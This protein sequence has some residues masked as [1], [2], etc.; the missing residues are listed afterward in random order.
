MTVRRNKRKGSRGHQWFCDL[1][2]DGKRVQR[3]IKG[4]RTRAQALKAE[5]VIRTKLFEKKYGLVEQAECRFDKFVEATFLPSKK[6]K[7]SYQSIVSITKALTAFFGKR[8]LSDIDSDLIEKYKQTRIAEN[9]TRGTKRS[10]LRVNKELQ[11]LSSLFTL[12]MEKELTATRPKVKLFQV[13]GERERYLSPDEEKGLMAAL[14]ESPWL[15]NIVTMALHTGMRRGEIFS[16]QWF[17]VN[18]EREA[19][20][21]RQTKSGK[22]RLVPMNSTVRAML[23]SL[24]KSS[25]YVFPS[26]KTGGR[27]IDIKVGFMRAVVA[28]KLKDFRFHDLRHT[29]ATRMAA[30]GADAFTLC[31]IFGWSDI[32]MALRYTHAMSD[33]K[34][35]A[36]EN[37]AEKSRSGGKKVTKGK[38]Q[39]RQLAVKS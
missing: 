18:F 9:T 28:A 31:S 22:D 26:P 27:L 3:V 10:P 16:L 2:I 29:A 8:L 17:D 25:G 23:E 6:L 14:S 21:L 7:K 36:V 38:R 15:R 11:V 5:A 1:T 35:Q 30:G 34:R 37:L 33:A 39:A 4:A 12:A 24:P 13:S 19:I 20:H 32:R